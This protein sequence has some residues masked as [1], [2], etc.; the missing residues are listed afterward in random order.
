[1]HTVT[2][3]ALTL[4]ASVA[5][6][7]TGAAFLS[8]ALAAS[9]ASAEN[10]AAATAVSTPI[11]DPQPPASQ[12]RRY[13]DADKDGVC[14]NRAVSRQGGGAGCDYV[15]ADGD[16]V[17]DKRVQ[18]AC[19]RGNGRRGAARGCAGADNGGICDNGDAGARQRHRGCGIGRGHGCGQVNR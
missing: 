4:V 6:M 5:V 10:P 19:G 9:V 7:M 2:K 18:G 11:Q 12:G 15:D 13:V 1:M 8:G 14:D 16:G 17:C 3:L